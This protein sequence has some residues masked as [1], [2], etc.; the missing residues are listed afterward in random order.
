MN[1]TN[2]APYTTYLI[3]RTRLEFHTGSSPAAG[4]VP[5]D[6]IRP[7]CLPDPRSPLYKRTETKTWR[8]KKAWSPGQ[9][10]K[11]KTHT[12]APYTYT[13]TYTSWEWQAPSLNSVCE[14]SLAAFLHEQQMKEQDAPVW[15]SHGPLKTSI[16]S[17]ATHLKQDT[18][19]YMLTH[20]NNGERSPATTY[21]KHEA[22]SYTFLYQ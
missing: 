19:T 8:R 2:R 10:W 17:P 1:Y 5:W 21:H 11:S 12:A 14:F 16:H 9:S 4:V 20:T 15:A 13:Y 7:L 6:K 18:H 3:Y 22:F